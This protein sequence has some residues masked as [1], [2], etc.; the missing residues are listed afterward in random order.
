AQ[1]LVLGDTQRPLGRAQRR[2][3][4]EAGPADHPPAER[5]SPGR[6]RHLEGLAV[7][8]YALGLEGVLVVVEDV[9]LDELAGL[10]RHQAADRRADQLLFGT[11]PDPSQR[12]IAP[13]D[14]AIFAERQRVADHLRK[15]C[16][17]LFALSGSFARLLQL[18]EVAHVQ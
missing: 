11:S 7:V 14:Y 1:L 2:Q 16:E 13:G 5:H 8:S 17:A 6:D 4:M 12:A 10:G 9:L 3:V 15:G 18:R